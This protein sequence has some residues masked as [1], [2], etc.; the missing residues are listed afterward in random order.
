MTLILFC[1][2]GWSTSVSVRFHIC[3]SSRC[4]VDSPQNLTYKCFSVS[5]IVYLCWLWFQVKFW[6]RLKEQPRKT[7]H[8]CGIHPGSPIQHFQGRVAFVTHMYVCVWYICE[9]HDLHMKT[10]FE[11]WPKILGALCSVHVIYCRYKQETGWVK[12]DCIKNFAWIC[13][14][15]LVKNDVWVWNS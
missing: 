11:Q 7:V 5:E 15:R 13:G 4:S 1:V 6:Q 3:C 14:P 10:F 8:Q 9:A 12:N 2:S